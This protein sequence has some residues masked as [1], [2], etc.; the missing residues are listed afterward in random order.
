MR[1]V[2]KKTNFLKNA[3]YYFNFKTVSLYENNCSRFSF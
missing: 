3:V 2:D 1:R